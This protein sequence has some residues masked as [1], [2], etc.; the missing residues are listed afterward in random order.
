MVD[1]T[2]TYLDGPGPVFTAIA[3]LGEGDRLA[4]IV[5]E[6]DLVEDSIIYKNA[7][8]T[9]THL[10][11]GSNTFVGNIGSGV[12]AVTAAQLVGLLFTEFGAS[13]AGTL[14]T[15]DSGTSQWVTLGPGTPGQILSVGAS[16][17]LEYIDP[18]SG[19][20][21][22]TLAGL[23][24]TSFGTLADSEV[25]KY[26]GGQ[27][28][29]STIETT[30]LSWID[31]SGGISN[32]E[33]LVYNNGV[34]V[35]GAV[36]GSATNLSDISVDTDLAMGTFHVQFT[37]TGSIDF[38]SL[39]DIAS[40]SWSLTDTGTN[41]IISSISSGTATSRFSVENTGDVKLWSYENTR[42]DSGTTTP[43]NFLYT[44]S[45][46]VLQS[47]DL[48]SANFATWAGLSLEDLTNVQPSQSIT[49]GHVLTWDFG[50][51]EW[52]AKASTAEG[53]ALTF[54]STAETLEIG[55][56]YVIADAGQTLTLPD[57]GLQDNGKQIRLVLMGGD[58]QN[59]G[60]SLDPPSVV[61]TPTIF[62]GQT[63]PFLANSSTLY[64]TWDNTNTNW[65]GSV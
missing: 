34:F 14:L 6:S 3:Q 60:I 7:S 53:Q 44:D 63:T 22:S 18:P 55:R 50:E 48:D 58:W 1:R 41:F 11:L 17:S 13:T 39:M 54:V 5:N 35:P 19:G 10:G 38:A 62:D 37:G 12:A 20:G 27:W 30:D 51:Q 25:L 65:I 33:G 40:N 26:V 64:L 28:V 43:A 15:Y 59:C 32:G 46:G 45:A 31:L 42:D 52:Q 49:D 16:L 9:V 56:G 36:G 47:A 24:D 61:P 8:G 57:V 4:G 23:T 2:P 29:N 21:S